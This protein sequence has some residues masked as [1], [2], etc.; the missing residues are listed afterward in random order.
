M[1]CLY[2][3]DHSAPGFW[4]ALLC[5]RGMG[6]LLLGSAGL[7]GPDL[8]LRVSR[9]GEAEF[10]SFIQFVAGSLFQLV[11]SVGSTGRLQILP[12]AIPRTTI[13]R[14]R[15]CRITAIPLATMNCCTK[16]T[17][18]EGGWVLSVRERGITPL[19][20]RRWLFNVIL[21][22]RWRQS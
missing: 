7:R 9:D 16:V 22:G 2:S 18:G 6:W 4:L 21:G 3:S 10:D 13:A 19:G 20:G 11:K 8:S 5:G 14:W 17:A 15:G 12:E 1:R